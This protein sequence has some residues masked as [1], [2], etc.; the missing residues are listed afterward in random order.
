[1]TISRVRRLFDR[2]GQALAEF[3]LILPVLFL[4]IAGIITFGRGWNIKQAV[5]D[6][7]RE[8]ARYYVVQ[9]AAMTYA[10]V[11]TKIKERLALDRIPTTDPPTTITMPAATNF[12]CA[13][14]LAKGAEM[15]VTVAT[16]YDMGF[17]GAFMGWVGGSNTI[18]I[19]STTTMRN[20]C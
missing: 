13:D 1:M 12:H 8:G 18:T 2:R 5:T 17:V 7:T 16:Q 15:Q 10:D 11:E 20:E 3:A 14:P 4:L 9:D 6:A 19:Q